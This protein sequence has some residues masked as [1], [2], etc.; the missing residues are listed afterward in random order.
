MWS[1]ESGQVFTY[2]ADLNCTW[3]VVN[4]LS[5]FIRNEQCYC[6]KDD[7]QCTAELEEG[8]CHGG[9]SKTCISKLCVQNVE[10]PL[11]CNPPQYAVQS[12]VMI[13]L[14]LRLITFK[15]LARAYPQVCRHMVTLL[16]HL[17]P[18]SGTSCSTSYFR[19]RQSRPREMI[20]LHWRR[21]SYPTGLLHCLVDICTIARN[22]Q[23]L[24]ISLMLTALLW[25][26]GKDKA[27]NHL[28]LCR[29]SWISLP[30]DHCSMQQ[31]LSIS[32]WLWMVR[33]SHLSI[34][35]NQD[36]V[37]QVDRP[38]LSHAFHICLF[39][40]FQLSVLLCRSID[41]VHKAKAPV[42]LS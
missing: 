12:K 21:C 1:M 11:R 5:L 16:Q 4:H 2:L 32:Q 24:R 25:I 26:I 29:S 6:S 35:Y 9:E 42:W 3:N 40:S 17:Q 34:P 41:W 36:Q 14:F 33:S 13:L 20:S 18:I 31:L 8:I 27:K 7:I 19:Q 15:A 30:L 38:I 23:N 28:C 10:A 37:N 39:S 22:P